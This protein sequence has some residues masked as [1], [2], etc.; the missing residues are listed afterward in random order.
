MIQ[1]NSKTNVKLQRNDPP[2]EFKQLFNLCIL[3]WYWFIVSIVACVLIAFAYLW[4]TPSTLT[5]TGKM[6]L[7]DKSKQS[8]AMSAGMAMLNSLPFGLGTSL[9]GG[10]SSDDFEKEI[11]KSNTL[12]SKVVNDLRLHTD[13]RLSHWGK[14]TLL[15]P[16][17]P[18]TVTLDDA[19]L[20]WFDTELPLTYHEID[21]TISK[22]SNGYT[23]ETILKEGK[24][25]TELPEQTFVSLPATIKTDAGTL[26]VVENNLPDKF[27]KA[28]KN[29]YTIEVSIVPPINAAN[30][31]IGRMVDKGKKKDAV[32]GLINIS[33]NDESL[34]RGID[35][36]N[37]L[38]EFYNERANDEK[39]EEARKTDE[40]V[41]TRLAKIDQEL[42]SSDAAWENTK[43]NF[44]ITTP[45][46]DAAEV[47]EKKSAYE[48]QLVSIGTELQLHDY[49][50]EYVNNPANLYEI[51]PSGISSVPSA[52]GAGTPSGSGAAGIA[53]LL[54]QHNTYVNQRKA[55]LKSLNEKSPQ[56]QRVSQS[57][58]E[59]HPTI[60]TAL[61]RERQQILMR[62]TTLQR[63][64]DKYMGRVGSAPKMERVL[65]EIGRQR[66]IKQ[67]VYLLMLQK[68]EETAMELANIMDKGKL[69]D[70]PSALPNSSKPQKK[71]TLLSALALGALLPMIVCYLLLMFKSVI[72]TKSDLKPFTKLPFIG[73][74]SLQDIDDSIRAVRNNLLVQLG[75]GKK[76]ILVASQASGDGKTFIAQHLTDALNTIDKKTTLVNADF[77]H[78]TTSIHP[79][80]MLASVEFTN[81]I[82]QAKA[83]SDFV[84]ID[85]PELSKYADASQV[86]Q[87][88]DATLFIVKAGVTKKSVIENLN[89]DTKLPTVMLALNGV[90]TNSKKYKL[91]KKN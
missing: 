50:S 62:Q 89:K 67:G 55:L 39:N 69:I 47:T 80:D 30:A 52:D 22:D 41:N 31:F 91:N 57:I 42:G 4:F 43:K 17:N 18:L 3:N 81:S 5:V 65:T 14:K 83:S 44:Q 70:P 45:E 34:L 72:D 19:H 58:Q 71:M 79:A 13:Y 90:D 26:T 74:L 29:G 15:Y 64:Y 36:I 32:S 75:E 77:R 2:F 6:Q 27:A 78:Q 25:E 10:A 12:V 85:T 82:A 60:L 63:E 16:N 88:A 73:E 1:N 21:L 35:F 46:I 11:L 76:V 61:K 53:S 33:V 28:F 20:Q 23:V 54:A 66:E 84:I 59:L 37:K 86:A 56:I 48:K 7:I 24:E 49:L 51:I 9:G 87:F 38:V 8:S 68:R 40:F